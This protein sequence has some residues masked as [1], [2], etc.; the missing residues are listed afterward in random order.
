[1]GCL[2][3]VDKSNRIKWVVLNEI[4]PIL[5]DLIFDALKQSI[6]PPVCVR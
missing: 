5:C 6:R 3:A 4:K 1:M 2:K